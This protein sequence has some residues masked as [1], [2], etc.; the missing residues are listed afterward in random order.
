MAMLKSNRPMRLNKSIAARDSFARNHDRIAQQHPK[1][2]KKKK[3]ID[4]RR[5]NKISFVQLHVSFLLVAHVF[6]SKARL[7]SG[8]YSFLPFSLSPNAISTLQFL[9]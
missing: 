7:P 5:T 9:L 8:L 4:S 2:Y 6:N 3:Q 1:E